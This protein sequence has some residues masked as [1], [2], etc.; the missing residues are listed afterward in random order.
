MFSQGLHGS[1]GGRYHK[2][3]RSRVQ[4]AGYSEARK[5]GRDVI[6]QMCGLRKTHWNGGSEGMMLMR[7]SMIHRC[8]CDEE[9][10]ILRSPDY[11]AQLGTGKLGWLKQRRRR[12]SEEMRGCQTLRG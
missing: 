2:R 3:S 12:K 8:G 11:R 4:G 5:R 10:G 1:E 9:T 7:K 6:V